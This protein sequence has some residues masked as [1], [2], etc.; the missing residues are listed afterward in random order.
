MRL[1]VD[2]PHFLEGEFG[3][4]SNRLL[5][6]QIGQAGTGGILIFA[7]LTILIIAYNID[8]KLPKRKRKSYCY[9]LMLVDDIGA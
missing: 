7:A 5:D 4:W 8:F 9:M 6:A 1:S 3:F 2:Y